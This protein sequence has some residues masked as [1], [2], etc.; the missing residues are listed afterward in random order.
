M[1]NEQIQKQVQHALN[2][3]PK[4]NAAE[5]GVTV[6]DGVVTLSGTVDAYAKKEEA[7]KTAKKVAGVKAVVEHI[8]VH[9]ENPGSP[10]DQEVAQAIVDTFKWHWDI[11]EAKIKVKVENGLVTLEGEVN[12]NYEKE[13]A[14]KAVSR[15]IGVKAIKNNIMVKAHR[16]KK[17][18]IREIQDALWRNPGID[19]EDI[20]VTLEGQT[21]KLMGTVRSWY[22]KEEAGRMAWSA[23]GVE[24]VDNQLLVDNT[25]DNI[26]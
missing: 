2:W 23:P 24:H 10:T 9:L 25:L 4:L 14:R 5:I 26:D 19:D 17:I 21:V 22:Q 11:P 6:K 15:L 20:N 3:H 1:K 8:N 16:V 18:D 12:W 13:A 7:E